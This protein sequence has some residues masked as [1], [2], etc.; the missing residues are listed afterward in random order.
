MG[1]SRSNIGTSAM[2]NLT[3]PVR[4]SSSNLDNDP[5]VSNSVRATMRYVERLKV[6]QALDRQ[7]EVVP[8]GHGQGSLMTTTP[9]FVFCRERGNCTWAEYTIEGDVVGMSAFPE[10]VVYI[11]T[12]IL[13]LVLL[14]KVAQ[15]CVA[16]G[17]KSAQRSVGRADMEMADVSP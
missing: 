11:V 17:N 8:Q 13:V 5:T 7:A 6:Q 16:F 9:P 12:S 1:N 10:I 2:S 4:Y 15:W 3:T 14:L